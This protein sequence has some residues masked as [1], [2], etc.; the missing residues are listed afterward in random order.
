MPDDNPSST[1]NFLHDKLFGL[2]NE[3]NVEVEIIVDNITGSSNENRRG[4]QQNKKQTMNIGRGTRSI[5]NRMNNA[6]NKQ[7]LCNGYKQKVGPSYQ[8]KKCADYFQ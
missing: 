6:I 1:N 4:H 3:I 7:Y 5:H 2:I 8:P